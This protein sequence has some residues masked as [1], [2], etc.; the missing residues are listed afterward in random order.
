MLQVRLVAAGLRLYQLRTIRPSLEDLFLDLTSGATLA[1][2][3]F[4]EVIR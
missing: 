3:P 1:S 4:E 2:P